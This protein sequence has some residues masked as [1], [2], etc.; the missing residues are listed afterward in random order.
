MKKLLL[1]AAV[2]CGIQHVQAQSLYVTVEYKAIPD[3][4][5][6]YMVTDFPMG[7]F[8]LGP[9]QVTMVFS[10]NYGISAPASSSIVTTGVAGSASW[11]AQDFALE[12]LSPNKKYV[13]FQTTGNPIGAVTAGTPVLL[14]RF[15][16][17]GAGGNCV[18]GAG[19]LRPYVNGVDLTDPTGGVGGGDF[20]SAINEGGLTDYFTTNTSTTMQNCTQLILPV[21][22]L[23][24]NARKQ[25]K[26]AVV[27]WS[28]TGED[29]N[30]NYY[31]LQRSTDGSTFNTIAK[32]PARRQ[33]GIQHYEY[34]DQNITTLGAKNVY[35]RMKQYDFDGRFAASGIRQVRVDMD[36]AEVQVFPNP[37][38]DGFYVAVP[39]PALA[40]AKKAKLTLIAADGR[41]TAVKEISAQQA[42]NYYFPVSNTIIAAGQYNLQ[43]VID[44]TLL[45]NK[46]LYINQ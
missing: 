12:A 45:S 8:N 26:N 35:Y 24:F 15:R 14:F 13:G 32:I 22:L 21:N 36:A 17:T 2:L 30:T 10:N 46:K 41:V 5:Y 3:S 20:S 4:F 23:D 43:I 1:A 28:V 42:A 16:V 18:S 7:T 34:N 31:D 40:G 27:K 38:K 39:A 11:T 29:F 33:P 44:G 37:V 9:S 19:T 6:V 25:D